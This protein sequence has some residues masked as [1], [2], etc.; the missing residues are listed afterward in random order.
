MNPP[1][2][3]A[4]EKQRMTKDAVPVVCLPI[5][6]RALKMSSPPE[7]VQGRHIAAGI[8]MNFVYPARSHTA[9]LTPALRLLQSS[10]K[11]G[12]QSPGMEARCS[13]LEAP[14]SFSNYLSP[15]LWR[16]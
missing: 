2:L 7:P 9:V 15:S 12:P 13:L 11:Q 1:G 14:F 6:P 16:A 3:T 4:N 8:L 5:H 10:T